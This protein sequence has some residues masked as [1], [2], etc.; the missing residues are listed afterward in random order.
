MTSDLQGSRDRLSNGGLKSEEE[1]QKRLR[2]RIYFFPVCTVY[3][4]ICQFSLKIYMMDIYSTLYVGS[5]NI[6]MSLFAVQNYT[7]GSLTLV[8]PLWLCSDPAAEGLDGLIQRPGAAVVVAVV[9]V[10]ETIWGLFVVRLA[11]Q[12]VE[13]VVEAGIEAD[14]SG[15]AGAVQ[16]AVVVLLRCREQALVLVVVGGLVEVALLQGGEQSRLVFVH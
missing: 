13:T 1:Q 7:Q 12:G 8:G 2:K 11:Q 10:C 9:W 6:C 16:R 14:V 5:T 4:Q 3:N 15:V